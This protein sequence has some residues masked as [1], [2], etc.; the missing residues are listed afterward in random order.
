MQQSAYTIT[1]DIQRA[2]LAGL[3][4]Y[5]GVELPTPQTSGTSHQNS[6]YALIQAGRVYQQIH[7]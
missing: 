5:Q 6:S 3:S 2:I 7:N 4:H 1:Q